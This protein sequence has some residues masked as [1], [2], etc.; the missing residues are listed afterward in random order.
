LS[1]LSEEYSETGGA[2]EKGGYYRN[3]KPALQIRGSSPSP[4]D[5]AER[6]KKKRKKE[7]EKRRKRREKEAKELQRKILELEAQSQRESS[8]S[9][10]PAIETE[11]FLNACDELESWEDSPE[12]ALMVSV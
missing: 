11:S 6:D 12:L 5:L 3:G 4:K 1:R 8:S 9:S 2:P 7:R 10:S